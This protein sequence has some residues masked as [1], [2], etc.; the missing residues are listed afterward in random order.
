[1]C[2]NTYNKLLTLIRCSIDVNFNEEKIEN[3]V[4]CANFFA[5]KMREKCVNHY[6]CNVS[7][8]RL[9]VVIKNPNFF[10]CTHTVRW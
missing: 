2:K 8:V 7:I 1:M 10:Y 9:A 6:E 5:V 4:F 3:R